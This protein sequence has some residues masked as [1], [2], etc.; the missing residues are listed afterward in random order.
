MFK[1]VLDGM[2]EGGQD[3]SVDRNSDAGEVG[4]AR[5]SQEGDQLCWFFGPPGA[6]ERGGE[7][8]VELL[9]DGVQ[10][11]AGA[12]FAAAYGAPLG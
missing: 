1:P 12:A 3:A 7:A 8:L 5:G 9:T 4:G 2:S 11:A 10:V 6:A